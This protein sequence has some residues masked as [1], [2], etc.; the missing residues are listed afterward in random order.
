MSAIT[1]K[2]IA[3]S[4]L[5]FSGSFKERTP[6]VAVGDGTAELVPLTTETL[7]SSVLC[8]AQIF[9]IPSTTAGRF[10]VFRTSS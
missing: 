3:I 5:T 9:L 7:P 8:I 6:E 2:I 1:P 4:L 10:F